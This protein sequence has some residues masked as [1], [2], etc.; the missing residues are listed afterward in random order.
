MGL[1]PCLHTC[2]LVTPC[3]AFLLRSTAQRVPHFLLALDDPLEE[4]EALAAASGVKGCAIC[5]GLGHRATNC[6]KLQAE[7]RATVRNNRDY[8]GSGGYGGEM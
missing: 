2:P 7:N 4:M 6:P 5:G 8:F 1:L 3:L